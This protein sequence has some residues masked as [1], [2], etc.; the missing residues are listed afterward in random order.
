MGMLLARFAKALVVHHHNAQI[1]WT[2]GCNGGQ[3]AQAH[4]HF[5]I[6]GH[7][8]GLILW[9]GERYAQP[10]HRSPTHRAP[11]GK[12]QRLGPTRTEVLA[13]HTQ[14]YHDHHLP[15]VLTPTSQSV[16]PVSPDTAS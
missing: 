15:P 7:D 12:V 1:G 4:E 6:T 3:A 14:T 9:L 10:H 8:Q 11:Q 5:A 13:H 16:P 2:L